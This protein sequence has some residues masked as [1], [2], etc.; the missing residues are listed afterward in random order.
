MNCLR[1][2]CESESED[3]LDCI[4]DDVLEGTC[5]AYLGSCGIAFGG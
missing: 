1:T 2:D 4:A 3:Y 5:D